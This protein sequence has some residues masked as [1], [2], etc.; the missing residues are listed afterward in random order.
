MLYYYYSSSSST[1]CLSAQLAR[2]QTD[3]TDPKPS[4][5]LLWLSIRH[6]SSMER[7][8]SHAHMACLALGRGRSTKVDWYYRRECGRGDGPMGSTAAS[9]LDPNLSQPQA[10]CDWQASACL[11]AYRHGSCSYKP[12]WGLQSY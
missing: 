12:V 1:H 10:D 7:N 6:P 3:T 8:S 9:A 4:V 2:R 11:P 5:M